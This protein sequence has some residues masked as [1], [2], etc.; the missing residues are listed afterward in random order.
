VGR[1]RNAGDDQPLHCLT[2][3]SL[4]GDALDV[5]LHALQAGIE[6]W[7][8]VSPYFMVGGERLVEASRKWEAGFGGNNGGR[9]K[10]VLYL[11]TDRVLQ[12][13]GTVV[14]GWCGFLDC[15]CEWDTGC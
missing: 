9:A 13:Q 6:R 14:P 1:V 12:M 4:R 11:P 3:V 10:L 2:A 15:H 8:S 5:D 7:R